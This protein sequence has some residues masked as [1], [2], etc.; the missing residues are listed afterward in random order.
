MTLGKWQFDATL[1]KKTED[2]LQDLAAFSSYDMTHIARIILHY[3]PTAL[4]AIANALALHVL[5]FAHRK[6]APVRMRMVLT[7]VRLDKHLDKCCRKEY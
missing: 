1:E 3:L 6:P 2:A 7:K 5:Q 4:L